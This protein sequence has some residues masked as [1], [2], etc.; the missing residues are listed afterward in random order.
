MVLGGLGL[1][2]LGGLVWLVGA[3]FPGFRF[4][5]LPG[6]IVVERPGVGIYFPITTMILVSVVLSL[7]LWIVGALRR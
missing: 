6:D 5:R 7:V 2:V 4:G 1:A 3:A